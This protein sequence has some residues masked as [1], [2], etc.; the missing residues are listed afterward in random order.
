MGLFKRTKNNG[1]P[2]IRQLLDL[3][4]RHVINSCIK[5][6]QSNKGC[7]KYLTYD[8]LVA[9]TFGQLNKCQ[10]LEDIS[11]AISVSETFIGDLGL[12]Q[13]PA[14]STMSDGNRQRSY[15]VFES[16]YYKLLKYYEQLLRAKHRENMME[17]IKGKVIKLIDSTT[18]SLCLS[19]FNWAKFRTAKGGIKIHTCWDDAMMIPDLIN[20]TPAAVHDSK[21][22]K[23]QVF[24]KGT[25]LIEDRAYLDFDLMVARIQA[26]NIFVTRIKDNTVY[27]V[28]HDLPL[29][30]ETP[31]HVIKDQLIHL[32]GKKAGTS[33]VTIH[34]LRLVT[35]YEEKKK[36]ILQ[37]ITNNLDWTAASIA[38]LYK[39]R[40]DIELFFKAL[41]QNLQVKTFIGTS[42]NAVKSQLYVALICYLL[43]ELIRR[44]T[45]KTIQALSNFT[46]RIRICLTYYLSLDY[47][48]NGIVQGAN[49]IRV[50]D[51]DLFD[52]QQDLFSR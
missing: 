17:E 28:V 30:V 1:R 51:P 14:R 23:K 42:E 9:L 18:I 29:P 45:C 6:H 49:R 39:K 3:I 44:N 40:W 25:I 34:Q 37:I 20:I 8:Q 46:E 21:G 36:H 4:P 19:L 41:K 11:T 15:H 7:H 43:L 31:S 13:S 32:T 24:A 47:V 5:Q 48:C 35:V 27:Q 10:T 26:G 12:R 33:G 52:R 38:A 50:R 2:L 22:F 16:L